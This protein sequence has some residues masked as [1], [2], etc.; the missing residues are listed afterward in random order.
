MSSAFKVALQLASRKLPDLGDTPL[1]LEV[2]RGA[3]QPAALR[4]ILSRG[5]HQRDLREPARGGEAGD[6]C[7]ERVAGG[8]LLS[9]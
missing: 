6:R 1:I 9:R 8:E 3:D 2:A 4:L 7:D 5:A